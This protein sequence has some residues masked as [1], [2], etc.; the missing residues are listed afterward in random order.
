MT[1]TT[2]ADHA[3]WAA[4]PSVLPSKGFVDPAGSGPGI[5]AAKLEELAEQIKLGTP[6]TSP[7]P[8]ARGRMAAVLYSLTGW[9]VFEEDER[10]YVSRLWA[11][12]W[13]C[14][15]DAAYDDL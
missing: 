14:D 4:R 1:V 11:E 5:A 7:D 12:D 6:R 10:A 9:A 8:A 15:E 13:D 3:I 2:T